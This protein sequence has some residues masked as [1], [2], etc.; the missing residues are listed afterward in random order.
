MKRVRFDFPYSGPFGTE[1][2]A[3]LDGLTRSIAH[4]P[5]FLW[6]LWMENRITQ[7]AG[8]IYLFSDEQFATN[9]MAKHSARLKK[10]GIDRVNTKIFDVNVPLTSDRATFWSLDRLSTKRDPGAMPNSL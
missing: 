7:E 3:A 6:K 2:T 8:G 5:G 1:M 9:C 10:I 4:E